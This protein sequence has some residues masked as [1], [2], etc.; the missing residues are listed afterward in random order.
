MADEIIDRFDTKVASF[1]LLIGIGAAKS[2]E[3]TL[4][5][6]AREF[7]D[8]YL[9]GYDISVIALY[10]TLMMAGLTGL[11]AWKTLEQ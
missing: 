2:V 10:L 3:K 8:V 1:W 9:F 4:E 11:V 6:V 5:L 7:I